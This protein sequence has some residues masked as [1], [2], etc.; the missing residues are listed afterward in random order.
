M[1]CVYVFS[2]Q[3]EDWQSSSSSSTTAWPSSSLA[4]KK[5]HPSGAVTRR[6]SISE[7]YN[8]VHDV[9][10]ADDTMKDDLWYNENEYRR[11]MYEAGY[12]ELPSPLPPNNKRTRVTT[13]T[14]DPAL[15]FSPWIVRG[16]WLGSIVMGVLASSTTVITTKRTR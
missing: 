2:H 14:T 12:K 16:L 3:R 8:Q 13:A 10:K 15:V 1:D 6:V 4:T 11:F 9:T 7:E 5:E